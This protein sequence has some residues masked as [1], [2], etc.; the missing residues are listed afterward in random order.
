MGLTMK[1]M[2]RLVE[3]DPFAEFPAELDEARYFFRNAVIANI[4][5]QFSAQYH[6]DWHGVTLRLLRNIIETI[7]AYC[8]GGIQKKRHFFFP[9]HWRLKK[10]RRFFLKIRQFY[11]K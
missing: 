4:F 9:S 10:R 1:Q 11:A 3:Y 6:T 7:I 5:F 2:E 8:Q